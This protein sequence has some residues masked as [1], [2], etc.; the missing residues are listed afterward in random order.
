MMEL[1]VPVAI[2]YYDAYREAKTEKK[3][4]WKKLDVIKKYSI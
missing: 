2:G 1:S 3:N 4:I